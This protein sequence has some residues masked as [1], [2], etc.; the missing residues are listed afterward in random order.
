LF[1]AFFKLYALCA[2]P[3]AVFRASWFSW[4]RSSA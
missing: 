4:V 1:I 2:H 3:S